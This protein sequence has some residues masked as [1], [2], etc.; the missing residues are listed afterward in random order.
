MIFNYWTVGGDKITLSDYTINDSVTI[1]ANVTYKFDVKFMVDDQQSEKQIVEKDHF[2][3]FPTT[4]PSKPGYEFDG[5]TINGVDI[6]E[7]TSYKI[8]GNT[9]FIA[10]FTKLHNV[11]FLY[12]SETK[13]TQSVRNGEYAQ[14]VSVE[15]TEYKVFNGWTVEGIKV[16]VDSYKITCD[17][18]FVASITYYYDVTFM[19]ENNSILNVIV[20]QNDY[21]NFTGDIPVYSVEHYD[22]VGWTINGNDIVDLTSYKITANTTFIAKFDFHQC[23]VYV[24]DKPYGSSG[25][26]VV[27]TMKVPYGSVLGSVDFVPELTDDQGLKG[28]KYGNLGSWF[29]FDFNPA[30]FEIKND[31]CIYP[32]IEQIVSYIY[33]YDGSQLIY[34]NRVEKGT[35]LDLSGVRPLG[36]AN[37]RFVGFFTS[38]YVGFPAGHAFNFGGRFN[39]NISYLSSSYEC[40][41]DEV[42]Y[43]ARYESQFEGAFKFSSGY[44][45]TGC[46]ELYIATT[47]DGDLSNPVSSKIIYRNSNYSSVDSSSKFDPS[48]SGIQI[49]WRSMTIN[50]GMGSG[51]YWKGHYDASSDS[52][53][54]ECYFESIG[55]N[56]GGDFTLTRVGYSS[57]ISYDLL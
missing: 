39:S 23:I 20:K 9:T 8:T 29:T 52:W 13:S 53:K 40:S 54:F 3:T 45:P 18:T 41:S 4:T 34:N 25:V 35:I 36:R 42:T 5:W 21:A 46:D 33:V 1:V 7:V 19:S 14:N 43:Y 56:T 47:F 49:D 15:S 22:F 38:K 50:I 6:V 48:S 2:A 55:R 24:Y 51:V 30:T 37:M 26:S 32:I 16:Q 31:I 44:N 11:V 57:G 17:V 28:W 10:K 12:E 27:K